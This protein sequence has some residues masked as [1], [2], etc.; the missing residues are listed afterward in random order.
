M[1]PHLL[2]PLI[3][4]TH[5]ISF[6]NEELRSTQAVVLAHLTLRARYCTDADLHQQRETRA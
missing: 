4:D 6:A 2:V 3:P 5:Q 1:D